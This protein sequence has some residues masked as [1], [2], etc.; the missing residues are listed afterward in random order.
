MHAQSHDLIAKFAKTFEAKSR[1]LD[2]GSRDVNGSLRDIFT[3][4][5]YVGCDMEAGDNVDVVQTDPYRLPFEDSSFDVVVA[6][7][8]LEHCGKPWLM[9]LEI[10]RVLKPGGKLALTIPWKIHYHPYPVDCYRY[11]PDALSVLFGEHMVDNDRDAYFIQDNRF[12]EIDTYFEAVKPFPVSIIIPVVRPQN[13]PALLEK[14]K[15]NA[16]IADFEVIWQEDK[17]RIGCP[18]M[19]KRLADQ[20][21]HDA[22]CFLGDDT[23][24]QPE[25]L[26][27]AC[28]VMARYG[29]WLVGMND[30]V[31][32]K[33]THWLASKKM[34]DADGE[35]FH[36]GYL[37]NF[38]DDELRIRAERIGKYAW[39]PE[40]QVKHNHPAF[41]TAESD[42]D[43]E[44]VL[45][46]DNW[47]HDEELFRKR[48]CRLSV[49]II[50][51]NEEAVLARC[52][53]SVEGADEVIV[54]D[55]GS[56]DRTKEIATAKATAVY[57]FPWC[58]D[59]AA[60]RNFALDLCTK[61]WVLSIDCDEILEPGGIEKLRRHLTTSRDAI[62]VRMTSG[63]AEYHVP[64]CFRR[65]PLI[66]WE[67]EIHETVNTHDYDRTD[68]TITYAT[69]PAHALDPDRNVRI[70]EAAHAKH[71]DNTRFMYYLA[72]EYGYRQRFDEA[73]AMFDKYLAESRWLPERADAYFMQALC[74]W[75]SQRGDEARRACLNALNINPNFKAACLLMA[76]MSWEHNA[77]Q[78]KRMA[79]SATNENCLF[80]RK[81]HL[82]L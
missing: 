9:A 32:R 66:R 64:R 17:E 65:T 6:A 71:P 60:A 37:H 30:T 51:K 16:G 14:I 47:R 82:G 69:S 5:E 39:S 40:A 57:D 41:G 20:A 34:L 79:E 12:D 31:T 76:D 1:V 80:V 36:T 4:H 73:I 19:V 67:G 2:I 26:R 35:F 48:C 23:D 58:D 45:D 44:R 81:S 28:R 7:N 55:T 3:E 77:V 38:C 29:V 43:Y 61:D 11:T 56:T 18:K 59:F 15:A 50:A 42:A 27:Y 25:F 13:M 53:E 63:M 62:G 49:A 22:V 74:Y 68:V 24:P 46:K 70:L 72:R 21:K 54:V 8:M 52:I 78:W 75:Y 33:P 10:D